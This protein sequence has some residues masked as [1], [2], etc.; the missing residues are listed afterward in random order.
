[1]ALGNA[2]VRDRDGWRGQTAVRRHPSAV[3]VPL[4][5]P[6]R[7][8]VDTRRVELLLAVRVHDGR[9]LGPGWPGSLPLATLCITS[10]DRSLS[11]L[12]PASQA[13][14]AGRAPT[15]ELPPPR[16]GAIPPVPPTACATAR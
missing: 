13:R 14:R 2:A 9:D 4:H 6:R 11:T 10:S 15:A 3:R 5:R 8:P 12:G 16:R 7:H 1:M